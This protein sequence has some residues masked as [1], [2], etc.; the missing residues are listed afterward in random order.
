MCLKWA[1]SAS[2][3]LTGRDILPPEYLAFTICEKDRV[4]GRN[5]DS[6]FIR[7]SL[8]IIGNEEYR[9]SGS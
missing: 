8:P 5:D 4:V 3:E 7:S 9:L 6:T 2:P 1:Y